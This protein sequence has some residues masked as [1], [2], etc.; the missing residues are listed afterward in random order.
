MIQAAVPPMAPMT[1]PCGKPPPTATWAAT[2]HPFRTWRASCSET[3]LASVPQQ[4][5]LL[6]M[7]EDDPLLRSIACTGSSRS[8]SEAIGGHRNPGAVRHAVWADEIER[9]VTAC[10]EPLVALNRSRLWDSEDPSACKRCADL[11]GYKGRP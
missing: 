7:S 4:I 9:R 10:G 1:A 5:T 2:V 3:A 11:M 6:C 8:A